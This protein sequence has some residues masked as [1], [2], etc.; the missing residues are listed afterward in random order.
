MSEQ[1]TVK[2]YIFVKL[3]KTCVH[4]KTLLG[5]L[6]GL[7]IEASSVSWW[8]ISV[9][10]KRVVEKSLKKD[11][12]IISISKASLNSLTWTFL[13]QSGGNRNSNCLRICPQRLF[14]VDEPHLPWAVKGQTWALKVSK[15]L[16]LQNRI[17]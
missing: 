12:K 3:T 14:F 9:F 6:Q 10:M 17:M 8:T 11:W 5:L 2:Y 13:G 16:K 1:I 4:R 15:E 7:E